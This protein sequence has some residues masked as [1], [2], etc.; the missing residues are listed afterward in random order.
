MSVEKVVEPISDS[1]AGL[2]KGLK[3]DPLVHSYI[4]FDDGAW[5][6]D[7][8]KHSHERRTTPKVDIVSYAVFRGA[9]NMIPY[10]QVRLYCG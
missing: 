8:T 10:Y 6:W 7:F 4:P 1:L 3:V 5:R 9:R 2:G